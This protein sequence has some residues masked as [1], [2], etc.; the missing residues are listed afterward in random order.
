[1]M[2]FGPRTASEVADR[3]RAQYA[4]EWITL[5]GG[6]SSRAIH[7]KLKALP[8]NATVKDIE[9]VVPHWATH[10][11]DDC[12]DYFEWIVMFGYN[13]DTSISVCMKCLSQ[14]TTELRK[15]RAAVKR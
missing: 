8:Q 13:D 6:R 5:S 2:V 15:Q 4:P 12:H 3:W 9:A 7:R 11:C 14:A 10:W 1:M